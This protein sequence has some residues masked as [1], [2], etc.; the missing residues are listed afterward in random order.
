MEET[1]A[2]DRLA[3]DLRALREA[4]RLTYNAITAQAKKQTPPLKLGGSKLSA[5]FSGKNV[6]KK[7]DDAAFR[8]LI[9]LLEPRAKKHGVTPKG[10]DW[11]R[12]RRDEAAAERTRP[13]RRSSLL[14]TPP[15]PPPPCLR[16]LRTPV[17]RPRPNG[18][19]AFSRLTVRGCAGSRTPRRCSRS[20]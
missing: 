20:R 6:P 10:I 13:Q 12:A 2:C 1:S 11:W 14:L 15:R 18:C 19:S 3:A 16:R 4:S 9:Q 7:D 5:W 8:Y 17:T